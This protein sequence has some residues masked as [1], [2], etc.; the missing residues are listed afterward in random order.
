[1]G[2][3]LVHCFREIECVPTCVYRSC[4]RLCTAPGAVKGG[5]PHLP[6]TRGFFTCLAG[7]VTLFAA[8]DRH[9]LAAGDVLAVPGNLPHSYQNPGAEQR[10][11]GIRS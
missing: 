7:R 3:T 9:E 2:A 5:T 1:M 4:V 10:A 6:G 11:R 8:G